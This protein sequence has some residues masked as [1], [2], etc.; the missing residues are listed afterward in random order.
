VSEKDAATAGGDPSF[1]VGSRAAVLL[2]VGR[3]GVDVSI[4][5]RDVPPPLARPLEAFVGTTET[6]SFDRIVAAET[7]AIDEAVS[8]VPA[9]LRAA[10][11]SD[12]SWLLAYFAEVTCAARFRLFL[13]I[14]R[15]DQCRKFHVDAVAMRMVTTYVG[16]GT[17]WIPE[18]SVDRDALGRMIERPSQANAAIARNPAAVCRAHR[19]DVLMLKGARHPDAR[20][21]GAVHRS[22]PI[23]QGGEHRFVLI[24]TAGGPAP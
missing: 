22:P 17:E 18:A 16:P 1:R 11:A 19:G 8:R 5:Q 21:R 23:E 4:W 15:D 20:G 10:L 7:P 14:V 24:A 13:G 2:E 6:P 3:P 12:M 9:P